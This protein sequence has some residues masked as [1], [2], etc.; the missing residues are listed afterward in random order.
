VQIILS[1][2][3]LR[4]TDSRFTLD[5][6]GTVIVSSYPLDARAQI[7]SYPFKGA[8]AR[9]LFANEFDVG[10][11]NAALVLLNAVPDPNRTGRLVVD[12]SKAEDFLVY[13]KPFSATTFDSI[14]RRPQVWINQ[15]GQFN[16]WPLKVRSLSHYEPKLRDKAEALIPPIQSLN[17][18]AESTERLRFEYDFPLVWKMAFAVGTF[19][20]ISLVALVL[21]TNWR[22][23]GADQGLSSWFD[24][25]LSRFALTHPDRSRKGLFLITLLIVAV[26]IPYSML[27]TPLD[28]AVPPAVAAE[29]E[30]DA[31][32]VVSWDVYALFALGIF[33]L[34]LLLLPLSICLR[35]VFRSGRRPRRRASSPADLSNDPWLVAEDLIFRTM[36]VATA[37]AGIACILWR[38]YEFALWRPEIPNDWLALDRSAHL[39]GGI[40]PIVP[41]TCLGAAIFWWAYLELKRMHSYPLLRRGTDLISETG[42]GGLENAN[43]DSPSPSPSPWHARLLRLNARFRLCVDLLEYPVTVLISKNLPLGGLV[44]SAFLGLV[45][46]VWG[47]IW[48]RY[49][50]TPEGTRFDLLILVS[51]L[52]YLLLL[53]Y[54]QVRYLWL[55]RSLL[56][57]FRQ[58]S[59]LPM[60]RAYDRIPPRVVARF[61]RFLRT[62]LQDDVDLEIPL[63]QCRLVLGQGDCSGAG[64]PPV[65][66]AVQA[67]L[68]EVGPHTEQEF[69]ELVSAAC[70]AP[71]IERAW[72]CRTL[73]QAYGGAG[74]AE[75]PK[76]ETT[77][78]PGEMT[79]GETA[80]DAPSGAWLNLAE[81]LMAV[82]IIYLVSQFAGPLRSM[83]S[84]LIYGP[85]LL[86]L[87]VAW[88]PFH[89]MWLMSI[90]IWVFIGVGVLA[91]LIL[92]IQI[93]R[94]DFVSRVARTAPNALNLDQTFISNL[95]PYA[96]PVAGFLFTAFPSL[97]YWMGSLLEPIGR[98]VK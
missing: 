29:G 68:D 6:R 50:P 70:A 72:S 78:T 20:A 52:G 56:Q 24:P 46:L 92:L 2:N 84:Q 85:I 3:D 41:V 22:G 4:Y 47:V 90:M 28:I 67:A 34:V 62:S 65:L 26:A 31:T 13:G 12:A 54:S 37:T 66:K 39:L 60:D 18:Q 7:W 95:L 45:V 11:Y 63:Q 96:V 32:L 79:A 61:G 23:P 53:L 49:I 40:S 36:V 80:P 55:G 69:F 87:A 30:R 94:N 77:A 93:E 15:V 17:P 8:I 16:V 48:P 98:A 59:L 42:I 86:L 57:L 10:R 74:A 81:E 64:R 44:A 33:T 83:S 25:L 43:S 19:V 82:R 51:L 27:A 97:S 5:F 9:R 58:L 88:Y 71:V 75:T 14:N 73:D 38:L 89:P 91:T 1:V 35:E 21:Y 76:Q